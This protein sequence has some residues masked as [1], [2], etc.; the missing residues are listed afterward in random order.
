MGERWTPVGAP[1]LWNNY[2]LFLNKRSIN[3]KLDYITFG[4]FYNGAFLNFS[5][6]GM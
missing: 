2:D 1:T 5:L 6:K 4:A 3:D